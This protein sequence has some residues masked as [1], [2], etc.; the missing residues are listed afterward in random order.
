[1]NSL[2]MLGFLL[3]INVLSRIGVTSIRASLNGVLP[4][5]LALVNAYNSSYPQ[6]IVFYK[7]KCFLLYFLSAIKISFSIGQIFSTL[8]QIAELSSVFEIFRNIRFILQHHRSLKETNDNI[9]L[10]YLLRGQYKTVLSTK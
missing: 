1:M 4:F 6:Y 8:Y 9:F 7:V 5:R 3:R 2:R 10:Y